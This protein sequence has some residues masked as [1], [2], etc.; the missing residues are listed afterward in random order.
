MAP[1]SSFLGGN[2][3]KVTSG[4]V[5]SLLAHGQFKIQRLDWEQPTLESTSNLIITKRT[6]DSKMEYVNMR[7]EVSGQ[8]QQLTLGDQWWQD[9]FIKCMPTGNLYIYLDD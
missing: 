1:T 6:T 8:S 5:E 7:C 2:P 4:W 3:I 9:P